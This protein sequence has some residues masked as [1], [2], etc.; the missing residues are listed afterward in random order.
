[1]SKR[2]ENCIEEELHIDIVMYNASSLDEAYEIAKNR[3]E[4][5]D[6]VYRD[7]QGVKITLK[8]LGIRD[9]QLEQS[10]WDDMK[11][12]TAGIGLHLC[13]VNLPD[14]IQ[15]QSLVKSREEMSVVRDLE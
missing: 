7:K 10:T 9:V 14:G 13:T 2:R 12:A 6:D 1:M 5:Q 3:I 8:C 15:A 11:N 4:A